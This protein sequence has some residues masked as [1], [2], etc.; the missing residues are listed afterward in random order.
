MAKPVVRGLRSVSSL[1][2]M[3]VVL[4]RDEDG[5]EHLTRWVFREWRFAVDSVGAYLRSP[6]AM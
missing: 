6:Y 2:W 3:W 4:M 5:S 1:D